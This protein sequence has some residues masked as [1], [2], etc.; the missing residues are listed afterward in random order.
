[1]KQYGATTDVKYLLSQVD[2]GN[3][4][5]IRSKGL[6]IGKFLQSFQVDGHFIYPG[7]MVIHV[8]SKKP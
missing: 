3:Y 8:P 1:M 2:Q 7:E 4:I 5:L 6:R